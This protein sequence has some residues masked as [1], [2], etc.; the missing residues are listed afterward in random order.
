ME[1]S[2]PGDPGPEDPVGRRSEWPATW[3]PVEAVPVFVIAIMATALLALPL[4]LVTSSCSARF[5][6]GNLIGELAFLVTVLAWVRFV[7]R[8]PLKALGAPSRPVLDVGAGLVT[9]L[10]LVLASAAVLAVSRDVARALLGHPPPE[11][12]QVATCVRGLGLRLLGPVVVLAAP[13]GEETFF[14]GFLYGALRRR[15][16]APAAAIASGLMFGLVHLSGP[17]FL[18]L[19]PA[20]VVVGVGLALVYE[21]RRSLVAPMVAHALF[22]LVGYVVIVSAR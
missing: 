14:R 20:L 10:L 7:N 5:I 9:G 4:T 17:D 15:W 19:V 8:G 21:R 3:R 18:L 16:S 2:T 1:M 13:L 6:I 22:N 12:Q 11:P